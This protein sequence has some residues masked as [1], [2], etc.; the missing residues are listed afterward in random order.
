[1]SKYTELAKKINQQEDID[2]K[3]IKAEPVL[4]ARLEA[5]ISSQKATVM[6]ASSNLTEAEA[7]VD[8]ARGYITNDAKAWL[9][10]VDRAK[11]AR[12]EAAEELRVSEEYLEDL[13][14]ELK[15]F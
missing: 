7:A 10:G 1:M 3:I 11:T 14:A 9:Q 5:I 8:K 15:L 6:L 13:E 12:D 4:K 2:S